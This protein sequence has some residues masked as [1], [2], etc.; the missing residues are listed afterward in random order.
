MSYP[1]SVADRQQKVSA[2]ASFTPT[3]DSH[4]QWLNVAHLREEYAEENGCWLHRY[5]YYL[6]RY[7]MPVLYMFWQMSAT[8]AQ[9]L[10]RNG[11]SAQVWH[12]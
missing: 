6:T 4:T 7:F 2:G 5:L 10:V 8:Q 9:S 12:N 11:F 1:N 3:A